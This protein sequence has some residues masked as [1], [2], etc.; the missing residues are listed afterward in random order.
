MPVHREG[1]D[2]TAQVVGLDP[3][4][5]EQVWGYLPDPGRDNEVD[6]AV[7]VA[8][9]TVYLVETLRDTPPEQ[10]SARLHAVDI[11]TGR[12]RWIRPF[13]SCAGS[14]VV[15]GRTVYVATFTGTVSAFD[16]GTGEKRWTAE[17]GEQIL[18]PCYVDD[19]GDQ[20]REHGLAV[21]PGDGLLYVRTSAGVVALR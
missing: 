8:D 17:T 18:H 9:G 7:A 12:P 11:A 6:A 10:D 16:T 5:G 19:F 3:Q 15:A 21:L 1:D 13:G 20:Y 2:W 4:T 14:P